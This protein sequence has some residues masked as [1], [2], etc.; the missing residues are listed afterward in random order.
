VRILFWGTPEFATPPLRALLGEGY[1]VVGVVTQP[2]KPQ[3]RHHSTLH[4]SPI[5][6]VAE[7][8]GLPV[9]QPTAPR[10]EEFLASMRALA[11][12]LSVVVAYGHILPQ[13]VI[14]LPT[15]GTLNIHASLLPRWRGAAPIQASLLAGDRET[16]ISVMRMV[17]ALDAGPVLLEAPTPIAEDEPYGALKLRLSELGALALV[18]ALTL[19]ELGAAP[20]LAQDETRI[21]Y[22]P[23]VQRED[24]MVEWGESCEQV[25]RVIRAFDPKPGAFTLQRGTEVKLFGSRLAPD[26]RGDIGAVLDIEESGMLVACATGGIRVGYVQPAGKRRIAAFDWAQGRGVAVGDVLG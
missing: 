15:L 18:E 2:D 12:D 20:E 3:G 10:G 7:E 16:G 4:P 6:V 11:P 25:S 24:A 13:E 21:T 19:H 17:A 22:A 5:K 14:D 9:L 1:D 8:E 26:A 23:K